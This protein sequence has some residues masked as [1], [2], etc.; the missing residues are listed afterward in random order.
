[1]DELTFT[2]SKC[3]NYKLT[4]P[5]LE[6]LQTHI[7]R[8]KKCGGIIMPQRIN[9]HCSCGRVSNSKFGIV[10]YNIDNFNIVDV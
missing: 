3:G 1:M 5:S 6:W 7:I 4:D 9:T 2:E 10:V 8:C